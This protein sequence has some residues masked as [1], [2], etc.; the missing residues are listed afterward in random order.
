MFLNEATLLNNLRLRYMKNSIYVRFQARLCY[1]ILS[2]C[3]YYVVYWLLLFALILV[4]TDQWLFSA[5]TVG[6]YNLQKCRVSV[7]RLQ[8]HWS[9]W[10]WSFVVLFVYSVDVCCKYSDCR[11]SLYRVEAPV[12]QW[13]NQ[14]LSGKVAGNYATSCVCNRYYFMMIILNTLSVNS[15]NKICRCWRWQRKQ[16]PGLRPTSIPSGILMHP[17]I[18]PQ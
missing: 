8:L 14:K 3:W 13:H 7:Q 16:S 15:Q 18:W 4:F 6:F 17:A 10:L 2:Y 9:L 1:H 11:Q 12:Q 5:F